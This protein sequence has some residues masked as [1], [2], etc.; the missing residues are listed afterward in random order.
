MRQVPRKTEEVER[1]ISLRPCTQARNVIADLT[2]IYDVNRH[3]LIYML[4]QF[5][6]LCHDFR[7]RQVQHAEG[8]SLCEAAVSSGQTSSLNG[9]IALCREQVK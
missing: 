1:T 8:S 4:R 5:R 2:D 6:V 9:R 7:F 3:L